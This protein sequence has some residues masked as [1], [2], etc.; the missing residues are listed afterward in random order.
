MRSFTT[1]LTA[2]SLAA[3]AAAPVY[4]DDTTMVPN[5]SATSAAKS[6]Q[7]KA[8]A[9]SNS[10]KPATNCMQASGGHMHNGAMQDGAM[11]DGMMQDGMMQNHK[12]MKAK[13]DSGCSGK[14]AKMKGMG[15][16]K[17]STKSSTKPSMPM[18]GHD[19]M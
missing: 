16:A 2:L 13:Q 8:A 19:D 7:A 12:G 3:L 11:Q 9:K 14:P 10:A 5:K 1:M 6:K 17:S 15:K 18:P 4:A